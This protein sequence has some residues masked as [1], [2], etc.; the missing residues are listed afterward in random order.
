MDSRRSVKKRNF[1]NFLYRIPI[2]S[3]LIRKSIIFT[4]NSFKVQLVFFAT[5][6]IAS[7]F[8]GSAIAAL[9]VGSDAGAPFKLLLFKETITVQPNGDYAGTVHE[10][11]EPLTK[12]G[13]QHFGQVRTEVS[14][15]MERFKLISANTIAPDGKVYAVHKAEI[16]TQAAPSAAAAPTFSDAKI[17]SVEFPKVEIG[18]KL[19]ITYRLTRFRPYFPNEFSINDAVPYFGLTGTEQVIIHAPATMHLLTSVRGGYVLHKTVSGGTQT[20]TATLKNPPYH[21]ARADVVSPFQFGPEFVATTFPSWQAVGNAYWARAAAKSAVTPAVQKLADRIAG[22][23]TGRAAVDALYDWTTT[24]IR[25]V[26]IEPG[27]SGWIPAAAG[28]TLARRYGD[29]KASVSLLIALLK[30]K[31]ITA[32]P[33]LLNAG[34]NDFK[35]SRLADLESLDHVIVYVPTYHLF[36]DPT[37][38]FAMP[39]ELPV[40]DIDRPV[41]LAS[42]QSSMA[43]TP[44]GPSVYTQNTTETIATSGALHGQAVMRA[45]G[46]TDWLTRDLIAHVPTAARPR[47]VQ[48]VLAQEG[49]VGSGNFSPSN[50]SDLAKPLVVKSTW[51]APHYFAPG[52]IV[53]LRLYKGF[54]MSRPGQYLAALNRPSKEFPVLRIVGTINDHTTLALPAGYKILA[55]PQSKTITTNAGSFVQTV[56]IKNGVLNETQHFA[57]NRDWYPPSDYAALR[58]LFTAAYRLDREQIVLQRAAA[59]S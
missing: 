50:P 29:C 51:S 7:A 41:I 3:R 46:Y 56:E 37:S 16:H 31:G 22:Q 18:S 4:K 54:A 58:Y 26:G 38:G 49:L 48:A 57:L 13:V 1:L 14:T 53:T 39:G 40:G 6:I 5:L 10:V 33:A 47:V 32:E 17:V 27:L 24:Q 42:D 55:A 9:P 2:Q 44:S 30:A 59:K 8:F 34:G 28:H 15:D 19:D 43:Q 20:I 23:K 12:L 21:P 45:T 36:L 52:P 35:L 11:I 25:W